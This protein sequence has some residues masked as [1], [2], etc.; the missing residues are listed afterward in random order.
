MIRFLNRDTALIAGIFI[1][2]AIFMWQ[3]NKLEGNKRDFK[4]QQIEIKAEQMEK[5][6]SVQIIE[7][8]MENEI[9]ITKERQNEEEIPTSIGIHT[10]SF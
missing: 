3:V 4:E 7:E 5:E 2:V 10:I 1:V 6:V 8:Q 9:N